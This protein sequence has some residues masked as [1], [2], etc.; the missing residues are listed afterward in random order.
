MK[1]RRSV[2]VVGLLAIIAGL[3]LGGCGNSLPIHVSSTPAL[4][5]DEQLLISAAKRSPESQAGLRMYCRD[6]SKTDL[7]LPTPYSGC[8]YIWRGSLEDLVF[9][10]NKT[11]IALYLKPAAK[12]ATDVT[13]DA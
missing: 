2:S 6:F 3:I 4:Q 11:R 5:R 7:P 9:E 8:A 13:G 1:R 10:N 12:Q